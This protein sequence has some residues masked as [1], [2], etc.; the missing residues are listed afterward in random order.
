MDC[1]NFQVMSSTQWTLSTTK[2]IENY[3]AYHNRMED[4]KMIYYFIITKF[5]DLALYEAVFLA[6]GTIIRQIQLSRRLDFH[7][8]HISSFS[9]VIE[10]PGARG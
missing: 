2:D 4:F 5:S 3:S 10:L 9:E 8:K 6:G 1:L 7:N